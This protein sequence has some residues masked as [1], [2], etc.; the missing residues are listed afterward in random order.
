MESL[1]PGIYYT[2]K[3]DIVYMHDKKT[4]AESSKVW[5]AVQNKI[6]LLDRIDRSAI[7]FDEKDDKFHIELKR[8]IGYA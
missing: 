4:I 7:I 2:V 6:A 8:N 1:I 5:F 3:D